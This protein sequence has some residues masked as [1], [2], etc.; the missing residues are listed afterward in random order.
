[1][2]SFSELNFQDSEGRCSL[3]GWMKT[4]MYNG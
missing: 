3:E 1:M 2:S 4:G